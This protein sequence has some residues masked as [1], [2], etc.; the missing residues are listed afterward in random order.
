MILPE[1]LYSFVL[2]YTLLP[3]HIVRVGPGAVSQGRGAFCISPGVGDSSD[4]P[5]PPTAVIQALNKQV[6]PERFTEGDA[7]AVRKLAP[8]V[9]AG[10]R[11]ILSLMNLS[12]ERNSA[13][14]EE[15]K[16]DKD[17][18]LNM[19]VQGEYRRAE[20]CVLLETLRRARDSLEA[21]R[22]TIFVLEYANA[23]EG[24]LR[25]WYEEPPVSR[26]GST[27][28]EGCR[29]EDGY[30]I[31]ARQGL[32]GIVLA[33]GRAM[34]S[35]DALSDARYE[36]DFDLSSGFLAR[37]VLFAPLLARPRDTGRGE[38]NNRISW[39]APLGVLQLSIG[40]GVCQGDGISSIDVGAGVQPSESGDR[41]K[42]FVK[43]DEPIA[44]AF[45]E[46]IAR[47]LSG[48]LDIGFK[49]SASIA[50]LVGGREHIDPGSDLPGRAPNGHGFGLSQR[51]TNKEGGM[52]GMPIRRDGASDRVLQQPRISV[53][54]T[55]T[56]LG[57]SNDQGHLHDD[58][59]VAGVR[60]PKSSERG[61]QTE[62]AGAANLGGGSGLLA[63]STTSTI[64]SNPLVGGVQAS[65]STITGQMA[66]S[67]PPSPATD[68]SNGSSP[69]RLSSRAGQTSP[70]TSAEVTQARSWASAHRVLEACKEGL[71]ASRC[72]PLKNEVTLRAYQSSD[73]DSDGK[74]SSPCHISVAGSQNTES[75]APAVCSLVSSLL[76]DCYAMLLLLEAGTGRLRAAGCSGT[77]GRGGVIDDDGQRLLP[78][79]P[80]QLRREDVARRALASG[81]ALL[82]QASEE[83]SKEKRAVGHVRGNKSGADGERVFCIPVRGSTHI[84]F[85][86][87]QVFFPPPPSP[88]PTSLPPSS[89]AD[90]GKL[91]ASPRVVGTPPP[92]PSFFMATKIVADCL[93][94]A[95]GWC[96]ALDRAEAERKAEARDAAAAAATAVASMEAHERSREELEAKHQKELRAAEE[97]HAVHVAEATDSHARDLASLLE[98]NESL[99]NAAADVSARARRKRDAAR[100]LVAW[101]GIIKR[102]RRADKN[103][104][105]MDLRRQGRAFRAWLHRAIAIKNAKASERMAANWRSTRGLR[106]TVGIW[107][108]YAAHVRWVRERRL[109]GARLM[110]EV[111]TRY[112]PVKQLFSGWRTASRA[113]AA[114]QQAL[115]LKSAKEMAEAIA[116]EA[117]CSSCY[118]PSSLSVHIEP[119]MLYIEFR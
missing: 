80:Q 52:A 100:A 88:S 110:V 70:G 44:E 105:L 29:G 13:A 77:V 107:E 21:D 119:K 75:L 41:K 45:G 16:T 65:V 28:M 102:T 20:E 9:V 86:V 84:I 118:V 10:S 78:Q 7:R 8:A 4:L 42:A 49:P 35:E 5:G 33:T 55:M 109:A 85:G 64:T 79:T 72:I 11:L 115:A 37:S 59:S 101:R 36:H 26:T 69:D 47:L 103:T 17:G 30:A 111:L 90:L 48:L 81:K 2:M 89:P 57:G 92:P 40:R 93:A 31:A 87:L 71:A 74:F 53:D 60:A 51:T 61:S 50:S 96:D 3:L 24:E 99:S 104:Q 94:L 113:L 117:S 23:K 1:T 18:S 91:P 97:A 15:A 56:E 108:R 46:K 12:S 58:S 106:R 34:R 14:G 66:P 112:S 116:D 39:R 73:R 19:R 6:V 67:Q 25:L 114:E 76:P 32:Q 38:P 54:S 98:D 63:S 22:A 83:E 27:R 62:I 82:A 68:C 95:L 43:A